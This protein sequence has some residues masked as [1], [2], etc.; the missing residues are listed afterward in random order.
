MG[1]GKDV[2]FSQV[3]SG[4]VEVGIKKLGHGTDVLVDEVPSHP[5]CES[6][7]GE[8]LDEDQRQEL[9]LFLAKWQHVF[10]KHDEDYGCT[11]IVQHQIPTGDAP[12]IRERYR[13]VPPTLYQEVCTLLRGMLDG[14]IIRE[15]SSP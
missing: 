6:L 5:V 14:G 11:N 2:C 10:S 7:Q 8:G 3:D 4:V 12:P 13:P 15:S 1:E 9:Q